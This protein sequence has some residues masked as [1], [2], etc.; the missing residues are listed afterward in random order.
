MVSL[1][2]K[3][4]HFYSV[5]ISSA[6]PVHVTII[7]NED[8][9]REVEDEVEGEGSGVNG[10]GIG[11]SDEVYEV[12][13]DDKDD[14]M[15][16]I[17]DLVESVEETSGDSWKQ[18]TFQPKRQPL[19]AW[20]TEP[21]S[22]AVS[23][24]KQRDDNGLPPLYQKSTFWFPNRSPYFILRSQRHVSPHD[25][26]NPKFFLW[27]PHALYKIPCPGCHRTLH[28]H[29]HIPRPRRCVD[30]NST[31]WIIGYRYRC[32]NC[33]N[34]RT[35]LQSVTY[36]SWDP[37]IM[38]LLPS[39]LAAEFP[40]CLSHRSG[41]SK[42]LFELMRG[43]FQNGVGSRQFA[44]LL[45]VQHLLAYD[46]LQLQYL[47]HLATRQ[48]GLAAW[49]NQTHSYE[50]FLPFDDTSSH[51]RHG[52]TPSSVWL[53]DVYDSYIETHQHYFNQHM[54]MLSGEICAI[55]RSHKVSINH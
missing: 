47:N 30:V 54:S 55:D 43:S 33:F 11:I 24:S 18:R 38:A 29:Q 22:A 10:T 6:P 52:Y 2:E 27:D 12:C 53:R 26:Y 51:G 3:L 17:G 1:R 25:L 40:A 16:D 14:D 8:P 41:L 34:P 13:D 37:R 48:N 7:E 23:E 21:F 45:H 50:P 46:N 28:R 36:R 35:G 4:Y 19:P 20:L 32:R 15:G 5:V 49:V 39:E 42:T 44:D 9:D 31:F